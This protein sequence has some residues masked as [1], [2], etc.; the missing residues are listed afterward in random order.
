MSNS[1]LV[2]TGAGG[3]WVRKAPL[4]YVTMMLCTLLAACGGGGTGSGSSASGG[5]AGGSGS[6]GSNGGGG[7][8]SG[9]GGTPPTY[10]VSGT[11]SGLT[12]SGLVLRNNGADD[13]HVLGDGTFVFTTALASGSSYNVTIAT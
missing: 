5:S 7:G 13:L 10:T 1:G 3:I 12:G 2:K 9:G 8:G 6:G 11:A 4:V